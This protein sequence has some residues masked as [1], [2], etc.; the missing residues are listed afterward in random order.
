[1]EIADTGPA[2]TDEQRQQAFE[3]LPSAQRGGT[4]WGLAVVHRIAELH[5][6]SVTTAN[7]P[8]G[9]P[10]LRCGFP[11]R[12]PWRPPHELPVSSSLVI[13]H[14]S[15]V[16]RH[17]R[18]PRMDLLN[19]AL[20]VALRS[21][22]GDDARRGGCLA[23]WRW[24]P[25]PSLGYMLTHQASAPDVELMPGVSLTPSQLPAMVAALADA[26]LKDCKVRGT[27]IY[28]P[29]GRVT[30]Y[31]AALAKAKAMP[32][33][34]GNAQREALSAGSSWDI[35]S[36]RD[37]QRMKIAKQD[38]LQKAICMMPGIESASVLFDESKPGGLQEK[39]LTVRGT[40][41]TDRHEPAGREDRLGDPQDDAGGRSPA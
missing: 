28:V 22:P 32:P 41:Q 27:K 35:G 17:F 25:R 14:S 19:R 30:E 31:L 21:L 37:R 12:P 10:H 15:F 9:A 26:N 2:L 6:G 38:E 33:P 13:S 20:L 8:E 39:V 36:Q 34:L 16:I 23:C 4:G 1:M 40:G 7:C 24:L 29:Q 11:A 3:L 5:G 18:V